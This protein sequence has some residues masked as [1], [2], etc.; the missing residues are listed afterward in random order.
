MG[1][2]AEG[3]EDPNHTVILIVFVLYHLQLP[4]NALTIMADV[5]RYVWTLTKVFAVCAGRDML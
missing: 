3:V 1:V 4:M 2:Q 5:T